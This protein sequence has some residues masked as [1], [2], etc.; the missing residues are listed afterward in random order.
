MM[1]Y[2]VAMRDH[3]VIWEGFT[4]KDDLTPSDFIGKASPNRIW[5]MAPAQVVEEEN[6]TSY[7]L[8]EEQRKA[9]ED[10]KKPYPAPIKD[11]FNWQLKGWAD[12]DDDGWDWVK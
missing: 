12:F 11:D 9:I 6:R 8:S 3:E 10:W 7:A 5:I 1:N 4:S 2:A